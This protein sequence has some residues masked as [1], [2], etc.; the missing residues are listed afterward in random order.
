MPK[1]VKTFIETKNIIKIREIQKDIINFYSKDASNY[2]K[3]NK[4]VIKRIY[5]MIPSSIEN[6]VMR[7][8]Y[9]KIEGIDDVRYKNILMS[10]NI[11]F[12]Q[13]FR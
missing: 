2:D 4:L 7:I 6:K 1:A 8:Q 13:A 11:L 3:D 9:K 12:H 10:S 5:E